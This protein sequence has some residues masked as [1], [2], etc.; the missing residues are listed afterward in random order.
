MSFATELHDFTVTLAREH[1]R[2]VELFAREHPEFDQL[3]S[4]FDY[5]ETPRK[6]QIRVLGWAGELNDEGTEILASATGPL[7]RW[8]RL[9]NSMVDWLPR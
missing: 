8:I 6:V 2:L 7:T 9:R 1:E 5:Q 3:V 4:W